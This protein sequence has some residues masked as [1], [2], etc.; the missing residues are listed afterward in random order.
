MYRIIIYIS[1]VLLF[2]SCSEWNKDEAIIEIHDVSKTQSEKIIAS[3]PEGKYVYKLKVRV[4][5][6]V[7]DT[8]LVNNKTLGPGVVDALIE[9]GD[10]YEPSYTIDYRAPNT[11]EGNLKIELSFYHNF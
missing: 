4:H 7:S 2:C 3:I 1:A 9:N 5:G 10:Y 8:I 6:E 11:N